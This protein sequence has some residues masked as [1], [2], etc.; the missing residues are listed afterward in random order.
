[1]KARVEKSNDIFRKRNMH[2]TLFF[3]FV[4]FIYYISAS[5]IDF[6]ISDGLASF[7][8][9]M[10][11][12]AQNLIPDAKAVNRL[13]K[14]LEELFLTILLSIAV[15]VVSGIFAFTFALFGSNITKGRKLLKKVVRITAAF[16]RNVPDIVWAMLLLFSFGQSEMT[17][18]IALSLTTFGML[19]R[20]FIETIDE[21]SSESV[22]AL[23]ATG[24]SFAQIVFQAIIPSTIAGI[25][26]WILYMI[27][28]NIRASTVIGVLTATGIGHLFDLYYKRMDYPSVSLVTIAIVVVVIIIEAISNK[29]RRVIL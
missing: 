8:K 14:I 15:T 22:E 1:M 27:E 23:E 6:K 20:S 11:W 19:T 29:I 7:P 3:V 9:A 13:P 18:F 16:F 21:A 2:Y 28:T 10:T 24:A 25:I 26:T 17:G 4:F 5:L 12:L